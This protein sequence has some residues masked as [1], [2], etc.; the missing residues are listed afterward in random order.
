MLTNL[1]VIFFTTFPNQSLFRAAAIDV[2]SSEGNGS[3]RAN[4]EGRVVETKITFADGVTLDHK[5]TLC[6]TSE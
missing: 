2:A 3:I 1:D 4:G 6:D 5:F